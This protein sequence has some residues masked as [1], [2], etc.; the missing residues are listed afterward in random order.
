MSGIPNLIGVRYRSIKFPGLRLVRYL[1]SLYLKK[2][3]YWIYYPFYKREIDME[4]AILTL[5]ERLD[6]TD[7]Q[8][9]NMKSMIGTT[10]YAKFLKI[11]IDLAAAI[12]ILEKAENNTGT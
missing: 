3:A 7:Y 1:V 11:R 6:V 12:S 5:K 4:Y 2:V 8:I 10:V 9:Y